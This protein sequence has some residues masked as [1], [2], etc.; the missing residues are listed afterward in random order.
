MKALNILLPWATQLSPQKHALAVRKMKVQ[1]SSSEGFSVKAG[2]GDTDLVRWSQNCG[3]IV[4]KDA[5]HS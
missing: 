1:V 2:V 5:K 3:G 4:L